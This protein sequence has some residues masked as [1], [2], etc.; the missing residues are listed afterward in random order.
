M[1]KSISIISII[2]I[3]CLVTPSLSKQHACNKNDEKTLLKIKKSLGDPDILA[4]W[5]KTLDCCEWNNVACDV[6]N[7]G[8]VTELTISSSN[9]SGQIPEEI[10]DLPYL[11]TLV[12]R[13]LKNLNGEIP[14]AITKLTRLTQLI[15]SK[16]HIS[17]PVPSFLSKLTNLYNLDLSFNKL[18]GSIPESLGGFTGHVPNI[19]LSHNQLSGNVPKSLGYLN[20]SIIDFSSNHLTGDLSMFFGAN[21]TIQIADFSRNNFQFDISELEYPWSLASLD[22][23][24]NKI[25][26]SLPE[27]LTEVFLAYFNVSYNRLCGKIPQGGDLQYFDKSCYVHNRCLCGSPLPPCS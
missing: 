9:I 22:L 1:N 5:K 11:E 14:L 6:Q 7:S 16:T 10:G 8:R 23:S 18:T 2:I 24:H 17:G 26:G 21:K 19:Y 20:F 13:D 4:S 15:I 27:T 12:F 25:Y 3:L